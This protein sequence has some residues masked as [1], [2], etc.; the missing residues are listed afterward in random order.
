MRYMDITC[1]GVHFHVAAWPH[2]KSL[3]TD[4]LECQAKVQMIARLLLTI[5]WSTPFEIHT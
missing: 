4:A 2:E 1:S 5:R 3:S